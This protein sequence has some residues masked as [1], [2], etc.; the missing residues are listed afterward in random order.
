MANPQTQNGH[1]KIANEIW[2]KL[3]KIRLS[4]GERRC[5]GVV[6]RKTY[7]WNKTSDQI[8]IRQFQ[9]L[10]GLSRR[11]V[12]KSTSS[13]VSRGILGREQIGTSAQTC[14]S[15]A[16]KY[17]MAKDYEKWTGSAQ[18]CTSARTG[19]LLVSK[20]APTK[21]TIQKTLYIASNKPARTKNEPNPDIKLCFDYW[22]VMFNKKTGDK[23]IFDFGK[24][25]AIF[26]NLLK[27]LSKDEVFNLIDKFFNSEDKFIS[28]A[29]YTIGVFKSQINKL[30]TKTINRGGAS[31][32]PL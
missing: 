20:R 8:S 11:C 32:R 29:G 24:D 28:S 2:D 27:I 6:M 5:L 1:I 17:W 14:T 15:C 13:L 4:D 3:N 19:N 12:C 21:D 18:T 10:S 7:G 23:Y 30:K 9:E 25:G 16:T 26:K 22:A 31:S